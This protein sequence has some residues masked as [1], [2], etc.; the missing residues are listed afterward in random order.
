MR[1]TISDAFPSTAIAPSLASRS[2]RSSRAGSCCACSTT[3]TPRACTSSIPGVAEDF[4]RLE[5]RAGDARTI[6][7]VGTVERRKNLDALVRLLPALAGARIVSVGP[8]TSVSR[9]VRRRG[10]AARRRRSGRVSRIRRSPRPSRFVRELRGRCRAVALRGIR[11]CR[12]AGALR[13]H[14]VRRFRSRRVTRGR[15]RRRAGGAGRG[16]IAV[17]AGVGTRDGRRRRRTRCLG[18]RRSDRAPLVAGERA[19]HAHALRRSDD[20]T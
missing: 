4:C 10:A 20:G 2:T 5:R 11:L 17:G 8:P 3:T 6:L 12:R 18:T 19:P 7:I 1:A 15:R 13:R 9:R 16:C 14:A